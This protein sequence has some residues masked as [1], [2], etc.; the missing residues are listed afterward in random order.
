MSKKRA[1]E[2]SVADLRAQVRQEVN[3]QW[4]FDQFVVIDVE[5]LRRNM[6]NSDEKIRELACG[7]IWPQSD[8]NA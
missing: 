1:A 8:M 7:K 5:N 2:F 3:V 4:L 6:G